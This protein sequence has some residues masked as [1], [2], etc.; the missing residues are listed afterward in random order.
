[1]DTGLSAEQ[2]ARL[3]RE[4]RSASNRRAEQEQENLRASTERSDQIE[5]IFRDLRSVFGD[6]V[7]LVFRNQGDR[8]YGTLTAQGR[9]YSLIVDKNSYSL[10]QRFEH[11]REGHE[12]REP[13]E[14]STQD[15]AKFLGGLRFILGAAFPDKFADIDTVIQRHLPIE[16]DRASMQRE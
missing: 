6:S 10:Y 14:G 9:K 2:G 5:D 13:Y 3:R 15:L 11:P 7:A 1:M 4:E 12:P 16:L 8:R